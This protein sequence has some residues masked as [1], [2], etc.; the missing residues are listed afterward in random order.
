MEKNRRKDQFQIKKRGYGVKPKTEK[1]LIIATIKYLQ[2]LSKYHFNGRIYSSEN[3]EILN[4]NNLLT[5]NQYDEKKVLRKI[6]KLQN[7]IK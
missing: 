5:L 2:K 7:S 4:E 6:K 3:I 1:Q